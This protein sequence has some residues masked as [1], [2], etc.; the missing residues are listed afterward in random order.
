[1]RLTAILSCLFKGKGLCRKHS[2]KI[3]LLEK[4]NDHKR[5]VMPE[6]LVHQNLMA[7]QLLQYPEWCH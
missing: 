2:K 1:M 4:L 6:Q 5:L 7:V 3:R